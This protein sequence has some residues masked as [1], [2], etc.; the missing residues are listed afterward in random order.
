MKKQVLTKNPNKNYSSYPK[1]SVSHHDRFFKR[2]FSEPS[3][4]KDLVKLILTPEELKACNLKSLKVEEKLSKAKKMDL[5]L[6]FRLKHFPRK[7]I[8]ILILVEHKAQYSKRVYQQI[9]AYQALLY[10]EAKKPTILIPALFYHGK[11]PWKHKSSFQEAFLGEFFL[12]IPH[13]FKKSMLDYRARLIDT[14]DSKNKR[15]RE[16]F[17]NRKSKASWVLQ[18]MDKVWFL[19]HNLDLL[20]ELLFGI[21]ELFNK[22]GELLAFTNYFKSAG[23]RDE[24]LGEIEQE[25]VKKGLLTKGGLMGGFIDV[26]KDILEQGLQKGI[27]QGMQQG[28]Q[29]GRMEGQQQGLQQGMEKGRQEVIVNM[30]RKNTDLA[31]ISEVTGLPVK[32]IK[33]LKR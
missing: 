8:H 26:E 6:S 25:A 16:F 10:A 18:A 12:K 31:F 17:K 22:R 27:Q 4:A 29:K 19:S 30:L 33:K 7:Q 13:S 5:I 32:E 28:L 21:F 1:A 15:L 2:A 3:L 23:V 9:L 24:D 20:R 11:S 14:K